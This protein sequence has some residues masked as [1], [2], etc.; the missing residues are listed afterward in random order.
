MRWSILT[1]AAVLAIS[2]LAVAERGQFSAQGLNQG[3]FNSL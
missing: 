3:E 1:I 2:Q